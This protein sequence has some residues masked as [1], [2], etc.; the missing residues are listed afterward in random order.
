[1]AKGTSNSAWNSMTDYTNDIRRYLSGEMSAEERNALE[2]KA[3]SDPFLAD[4]LEGAEQLTAQEFGSD[5]DEFT[6][7]IQTSTSKEP[8][9]TV[10]IWVW[11]ARIAAGVLLVA[12]SAYLIWSS[13]EVTQPEPSLALESAGPQPEVSADTAVSTSTEE[14]RRDEGKSELQHAVTPSSKP[15]TLAEHATK[16]EEKDDEAVPAEKPLE[17]KEG[18]AVAQQ[19]QGIPPLKVDT[20]AEDIEP[21]AL[22]K[23]AAQEDA[24]SKKKSAAPTA[25]AVAKVQHMIRG[26]VTSQE[27]GAPIPGVNVTVKGSS[28]G[29][30]TGVAGDYQLE[31]PAGNPTLVFSFIGFQ[32]SEIP[33]GE[34]TELNVQL[35]ADL[36][37]LSEVVV[38]GHSTTP[39]DNLPLTVEL[40]HP[41]GGNRAFKQYL[42]QNIRYPEDAVSRNVEGRVTVEFTIEEDGNLTAF[43]VV[44]GI[45]AGCDEELIRLI[46]EGPRWVPTRQNGMPVRDKA[47]VRLKFTLPR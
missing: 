5:L 17:H 43:N 19:S 10:S 7:K 20:K 40:A 21:A 11:T 41:E 45:G 9:K 6:R 27:D 47:R 8:A 34:R 26:K 16:D 31:T 23:R 22:A 28:V 25:G 18:L 39:G 14:F 15:A 46:S 35:G 33:A 24:E 4:A 30:V 42:E 1:M 29:T 13:G 12:V 32:S 37:Q 44:R 3:L 38:V 36:A 2:R